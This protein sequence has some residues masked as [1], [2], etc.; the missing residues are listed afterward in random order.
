MSGGSCLRRAFLSLAIPLGVAN[1][2]G[3]VLVVESMQ[4]GLDGVPL[5][6][7]QFLVAPGITTCFLALHVMLQRRWSGILL[8]AASAAAAAA[9]LTQIG[10]AIDFAMGSVWLLVSLV[11]GLLAPL[12]VRPKPDG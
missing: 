8:A 9:T 4:L 7:W 3:A 1:V 12:A 5:V 2:V 6:T 10:E 11:G